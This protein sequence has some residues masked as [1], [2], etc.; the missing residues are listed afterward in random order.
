MTSTAPSAVSVSDASAD[1]TLIDDPGLGA[2]KNGGRWSRREQG[3]TTT[4]TLSGDWVAREDGVEIGVGGR[5]LGPDVRSI[6]FES[7]GLGRW[8]SG[9]IAFLLS[10]RAAASERDIAFE[11]AGLPEAAQ[12][13]LALVAPPGS[14]PPR[15]PRA[16]MLDRTGLWAMSAA[17]EAAET[18]ALVGNI[19]LR[20]AM[21]VRGRAAMRG[22]DLIDTMYGT[23]AAALPLVALVNVLM[24]GI[25]AFIGVTELQTLGAGVYVADL[26]AIGMVREMA[27]LM[28]AII[29]CGRT[30]AAFA[31]NIAAMQGA[32][33]IDALRA[34]GIPVFDYLIL[35]RVL[36]L[37]A[38][39]PLLYVF[40]CVVGIIGGLIV[41]A[42]TL[43]VS[44]TS[45]L[46]MAQQSLTLGFLA[47]GLAKSVAFGA[48]IA[49]VSLRVGLR[50]GRNAAAVG[51]AATSAVVAG[52]VGVIALDAVI[53][54]CAS[55]LGI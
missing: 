48:V 45:F 19:F 3:S 14:P 30:G 43:G 44:T 55:V 33:E 16:P 52:I 28:T 25:L 24:G 8:D 4:I 7:T 42:M 18:A 26:V 1:R 38:M 15:G 12:R 53:D 31:A 47:L 20:G 11:P 40:G 2:R 21:A 37:T 51:A 10:F 36:A 41:G 49:V 32:E 13:L 9:L 39:M 23:G 17:A 35:P 6:S 22:R 54:L 34:V 27:P 29:I 50:A 46:V 5:N